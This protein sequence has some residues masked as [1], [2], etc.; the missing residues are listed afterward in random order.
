M[1]SKPYGVCWCDCHMQVDSDGRREFAKPGDPDLVNGW[2]K[3]TNP[4]A[5]V[6]ACARCV[7]DHEHFIATGLD[8]YSTLEGDT[9]YDD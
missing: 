7:K 6:T 9:V 8:R 3:Y 4:I 5:L 1:S 2:P